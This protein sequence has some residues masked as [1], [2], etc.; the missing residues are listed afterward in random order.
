MR[1]LNP[2]LLP[3]FQDLPYVAF[4]FLRSC[5]TP[6]KYVQSGVDR[7]GYLEPVELF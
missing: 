7:E 4:I 2:K 3:D 5:A 6:G 1:I